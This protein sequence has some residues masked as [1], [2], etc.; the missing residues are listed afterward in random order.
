M[1]QEHAQKE[2]SKHLNN[3]DVKTL[4]VLSDGGVYINNDLE[5]MKQNALDRGKKIFIFKGETETTE[6]VVT[7]EVE[8]V[9]T[10]EPKK[11]KKK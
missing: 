6:D 11:S 9:K 10:E 4:C 5:V 8:E 2:A 1:T 3:P 7:K